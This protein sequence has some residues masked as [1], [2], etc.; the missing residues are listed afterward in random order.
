VS[1]DLVGQ[2]FLNAGRIHLVEAA[3][4][5]LCDTFSNCSNPGQPV[6]ETTVEGYKGT[7]RSNS[8]SVAVRY[9]P[10]GAFLLSASVLLKLDN[11]GLRSKVIPLVSATYTF[12]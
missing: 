8:A 3:A 10:F 1:T 4:P 7:Y 12:H 11:G 6:Q 9:R 2:T 5:G